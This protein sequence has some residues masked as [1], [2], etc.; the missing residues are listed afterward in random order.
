MVS[1]SSISL[2]SLN[3]SILPRLGSRPPVISCS[4]VV[5]ISM[6]RHERRARTGSQ[7]L[8]KEGCTETARSSRRI[9]SKTVGDAAGNHVWKV[10]MECCHASVYFIFVYSGKSPFFPHFFGSHLH[11]PW[12]FNTFTH[13]DY[14]VSLLLLVFDNTGSM[15]HIIHDIFLSSFAMFFTSFQ[16]NSPRRRKLGV[17]LS[18]NDRARDLVSPGAS[19]DVASLSWLS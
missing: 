15:T 14:T 16:S 5:S 4:N 7:R 9:G 2:L 11:K 17:T 13:V 1:S 18:R 6:G 8:C 19:L 3:P 12:R 10:V